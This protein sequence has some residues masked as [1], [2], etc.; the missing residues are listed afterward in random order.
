MM[1]IIDP[2]LDLDRFFHRVAAT[3]RRVLLLDYDG[4]LAPFRIERDEAVPHPGVREAL[5]SII[6]ACRSR[7]VLISGR[8]IPD[9]IP[10]LGLDPPPEIW[11]SHGWERQFPDGS[12]EIGSPDDTALRAMEIARKELAEEGNGDRCEE[13]PGCLALHWRGQEDDERYQ[14]E[15]IYRAKWSLL[16]RNYN[17]SL[18]EFDGGIEL[19]ARGRNKAFVVR[20]VLSEMGMGSVAAFLGDDRTDEEAFRDLGEN[21]LAVLVREA[22][23][24][25]AAHLW[26]RPP[27]ELLDFLHR[28]MEACGSRVPS[29]KSSREKGPGI[30]SGGGFR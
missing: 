26:I 23:R 25:T 5:R 10:L 24:P 15:N 22:F 7:L 4:T 17:L 16:A 27:D 18:I 1:K 29:G 19:R 20:S 30:R 9:L 2:D 6:D 8:T 13:K 11:G 3:E 12:R 28:W 14:L 21:D